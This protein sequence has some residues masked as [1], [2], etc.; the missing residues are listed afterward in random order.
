M[1][2]K[3][4][5]SRERDQRVKGDPEQA[6]E[7][8]IDR[9]GDAWA[10]TLA[11]GAEAIQLPEITLVAWPPHRDPLAYCGLVSCS[12]VVTH[13]PIYLSTDDLSAVFMML[14]TE[15]PRLIR[16]ARRVVKLNHPPSIFDWKPLGRGSMTYPAAETGNPNPR[17]QSKGDDIPRERLQAIKLQNLPEEFHHHSSQDPEVQIEA[18]ASVYIEPSNEALHSRYFDLSSPNL[19]RVPKL[20]VVQIYLCT[21]QVD[22]MQS[23][24]ECKIRI[25]F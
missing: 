20:Q 6:I 15:S 17:R 4:S 16:E 7:L 21:A 10:R 11:R 2:K 13:V 12:L 19:T 22:L 9:P 14:P 5:G 3:P 18:L 1:S 8:R 24:F 25:R 23:L